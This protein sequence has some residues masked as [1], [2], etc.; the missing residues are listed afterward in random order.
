L[1]RRIWEHKTNVVDG[2]SKRYGLHTLVHAEFHPTTEEA[3]LREK[4][5]K[6]WR[7]AWKLKLIEGTNPTWR[8]LSGEIAC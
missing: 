7:R 5:I 2:F 1:N 3:I 8:D 6:A 4:R